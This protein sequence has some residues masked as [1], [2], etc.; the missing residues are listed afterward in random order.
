[1]RVGLV[2]V[3]SVPNP[4]ASGGAL[5]AWT[6]ML[7]LLEHGHDVVVLPLHYPEHYDPTNT[8]EE[9]R[10]EQVRATGADVVPFVSRSTD[11]FRARPRTL[12]DRIRRALRP[13][14]A[15]LQPHLVDAPEMARTITGLGLDAVWA[16]HWESLAATA[17]VDVP[18]FGA[19]GDPPLLS[20]WYRFRAEMP[21]P[22]ALR[23]VNRLQT[24]ARLEPPLLVR[25]LN[26]C[27]ATGAFAAHH[28]AWLRRRGVRGCAYLH[29]PVPD[30]AG[31]AWREQRGVAEKPRILLV[32]HL[33]GVVTL[34]GLRLF[35]SGVLPRLERELGS[36]GFEVRIAG[37]YEP[38]PDVARALNRPSVTFLGHVEGADDEFRSAHALVVP[39]SISLGIR[40]RI[41]TA[42]SHGTCVV[43]HDANAKGIPELRHEQNALLGSTAGQLA[44]GVLR[45]IR[46]EPLRQRLEAGAR[47]TYERWFAP[48]V[49]AGAIS[50]TLERIARPAER[51]PR[52]AA[53]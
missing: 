32:G 20:A 13:T 6:V 48:P 31:A 15:E 51:V 4:T 26:E 43:S 47:G 9:A 19:V 25:L 18:R 28:A 37:G 27:A 34:N 38:P 29:T 24:Q 39:N 30:P 1:V 50:A 14:D 41:V 5:T 45:A 17:T 46:D 2:V 53:G 21:R 52:A 11:W 36:D 49:A 16:Y 44:D 3:G 12:P 42:F 23:R 33:K 40:V 10:V 7:H 22:R 8:S 35:A